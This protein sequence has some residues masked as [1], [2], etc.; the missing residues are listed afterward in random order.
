MLRAMYA[1][2]RRV[3]NDGKSALPGD[4][5]LPGFNGGCVERFDASTMHAAQ[6]I[7]ACRSSKPSPIS[8]NLVF[9]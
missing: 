1:Q 3:R 7:V 9:H 2:Q 8:P 6:V 5:P 4:F